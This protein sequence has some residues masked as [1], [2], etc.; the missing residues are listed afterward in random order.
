MS[1]S[2]L[3]LPGSHEG[4]EHSATAWP[5]TANGNHERHPRINKQPSA[6]LEHTEVLLAQI[7]HHQ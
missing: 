7:R 4:E 1:Y 5:A 6:L 3:S 2:C